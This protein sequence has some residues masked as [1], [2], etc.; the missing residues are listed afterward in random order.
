MNNGKNDTIYI[1]KENNENSKERKENINNLSMY[2]HY[3]NILIRDKK[4]DKKTY[5]IVKDYDINKLLNN[6]EY[7]QY[8]RNYIAHN[9]KYEDA[10]DKEIT[11]FILTKINNQISKGQFA[12]NLHYYSRQRRFN[13]KRYGKKA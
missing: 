11:S 2:Y 1:F 12:S 13:T 3:I 9:S 8:I 4:I 10:T 7:I 6:N 5:D